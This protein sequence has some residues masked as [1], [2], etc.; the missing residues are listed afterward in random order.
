MPNSSDAKKI[1]IVDDSATS[2]EAMRVLLTGAGHEVATGR[3]GIEGIT[4]AYRDHPDLIVSDIVMPELDGYQMCRLLKSDPL[5]G[6]LPVILL[7][8]LNDQLDRFWASQAGADLFVGKNVAQTELLPAIS[9]LLATAAPRPPF[10]TSGELR[11]KPDMSG[12]GIKSRVAHLLDRLL[13]D[14]TVVSGLRRIGHHSQDPA[15]LAAEVLAFLTALLDFR[16]AVLTLPLFRGDVDYVMAREP[17]AENDVD[18]LV[19]GSPRSETVRREIVASGGLAGSEG[20]GSQKARR[21]LHICQIPLEARGEP[22]GALSLMLRG[23]PKVHTQLVLDLVR[24]ELSLVADYLVRMNRLEGLRSDFQAMVVHD[25]RSPLSGLLESAELLLSEAAGPL[26]EE[27]RM[28]LDLN[29]DSSR[30]MLGLVN[31][32][33]DLSKIEAGRMELR[34]DDVELLD[35]AAEVLPLYRLQA[36]KAGLTLLD[37]PSAR[38]ALFRADK[39]K[40]K[41]LM[42]NLLSNAIKFTPVGG[43]VRFG[44]RV[45]SDTDESTMEFYVAD[46]GSGIAADQIPLLFEKYRQTDTGRQTKAKGTGLGLA[47]CRSIV[48][49]HEWTIDVKSEVGQGTMFSIRVPLPVPS[50]SAGALPLAA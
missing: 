48:E 30:S 42:G 9:R 7:T 23:Q 31:D 36:E 26:T 32:L 28:F 29:R 49:A 47:I 19:Q 27:Q 14:S 6:H 17:G 20:R 11:T 25:L 35:L 38:P 40:L 8:G 43:T 50:Q 10:L 45:E 1:L 37:E 33:L 16:L 24:E 39:E 15:T 18:V 13:F 12:S 3:D 4:C 34:L 44:W 21:G 41:Q 22:C 2:I 5:T 46:T